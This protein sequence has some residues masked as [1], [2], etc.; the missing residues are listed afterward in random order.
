MV[1]AGLAYE[2][3]KINGLRFAIYA[4]DVYFWTKEIWIGDH[5]NIL[6]TALNITQAYMKRGGMKTSIEKTTYLLVHRGKRIG[7]KSVP[8]FDLI[9]D[10]KTIVTQSMIK[11]LGLVI[12]ERY[13][14]RE[15]MLNVKHHWKQALNIIRKTISKSSGAD[16]RTLRTLVRTF[17][18]SK[19]MYGYNYF[20]LTNA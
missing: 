12:D 8:M 19:S 14:V 16:E 4:N 7:R 2:L 6:K 11:N 20:R 5:K 13:D 10:G 17:L 1:I 9:L 18:V 3:E 15:W